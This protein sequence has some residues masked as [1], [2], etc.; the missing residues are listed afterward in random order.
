MKDQGRHLLLLLLILTL[1]IASPLAQAQGGGSYTLY[2]DLKVDDSKVSEKVPMSISVILYSLGGNVLGRQ[3][4]PSGGRYRFTNLRQGEYQI[5]VEVESSEIA[6]V[7]VTLAGATSTDFRQDLEFEWKPGAMAAKPRTQTISTEDVYKRSKINEGL[8]SKAQSAVDKKKYNEAVPLL[9][10][11]LENDRQDFQSWTELGTVYLLMEKPEDAEQSYLRAIEVRPR[12]GLAL[13]NLGR[14]RLSQKKPEGAIEPLTA[15]V[16][17]QPTSADAN[18]YLGE[19]YLQTKKGSR[20]VTYLTEAGRL[21][22]ADAHLRLGTLYNA[23]GMKDKAALEYEEFLKKKPDY[24][25]RKKLEQ[26]ISSNKKS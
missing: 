17:L 2:G 11:L 6:R 21:G 19:A 13:L 22:R 1:L 16:E 26:Y 14:V 23:A 24:A 8:F 12:F 5:G 18:Y 25:D 20:A 7:Q 10:Q 9:K 15:A 3:T 4:V